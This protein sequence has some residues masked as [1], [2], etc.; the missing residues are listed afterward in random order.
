MKFNI[1]LYSDD[2]DYLEKNL[3]DTFS[4]YQH[5]REKTLLDSILECKASL[6][7]VDM[8]FV[9]HNELKQIKAN[10]QLYDLPVVAYVDNESYKNKL[11]LYELDVKCI[12]DKS[13]VAQNEIKEYLLS[14]LRRSNPYSGSQRD[15]FIKSLLRYEDSYDIIDEVLRAANY[16]IHLHRLDIE[17]A[18]DVRAA[19]VML[20]IGLKKKSIS[21]IYTLI[22]DMQ[23]SERIPKL[24][25]NY[26]NPKTLEEKIIYASL[27][28]SRRYSEGF[29][30]IAMY[31]TILNFD[32]KSDENLL[33]EAYSIVEYSKMYISCVHDINLFWDELNN[34]ANDHDIEIKLINK[35]LGDIYKI[36]YFFLIETNCF[37]IDIDKKNSESFVI[38]ICTDYRRIDNGF[39]LSALEVDKNNI[40]VSIKENIG[41]NGYITIKLNKKIDKKEIE[42]LKED[43]MVRVEK[44]VDTG[45]IDTMHYQ[46]HQKISAVDFLKEF[47]V[48]TGLLDDLD[49]NEEEAQNLL[50]QSE[51]LTN[52]MLISFTKVLMNYVHFLNETIEFRDLAYSISALSEV[53]K[54]VDVEE[55][56]EGIKGTLKQYMSGVIGDLISWKNIIFIEQATIDIHYLDASLLDNCSTIENMIHSHG[57]EDDDDIEFF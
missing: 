35:Y 22:N 45:I 47:D 57:S 17:H 20:S 11:L 29:R 25:K 56:D 32:S 13:I 9:L 14:T 50:H 4:I 36:L 8:E 51:K 38:K 30:A 46:D 55:L 33:E 44:K 31:N 5:D 54:N 42:N 49:E 1:L 40:E 52:D 27:A 21:K 15:L 41:S 10:S 53:L 24:M 28:T 23:V 34:M 2:N 16:L 3:S 48:E 39:D 19:L 18:A 26:H 6:L 12:L 43:N 7:V 37:S